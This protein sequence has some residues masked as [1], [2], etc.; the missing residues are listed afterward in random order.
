MALITG[1]SSG[2]GL[3][4]ALELA[5]AGFRVYATMRNLE[6]K[7]RLLAAAEKEKVSVEILELDV[8]NTASVRGTVE[9]VQK[10]EGQIDLLVNNA[11][12][13][14]GGFFETLKDEEIRAQL[15][16][17][18][19]GCINMI[20][21]VLPL[22]RTQRSGT[23]INVSSTSGLAGWPGLSAYVT[24]KFALEGFSESLWH[25][26]SPF[27]IN[28]VLIEPGLYPTEIVGENLRLGNE[29]KEERSG[30]YSELSK[31]LFDRF[32]Q[33]IE[34]L[35]TDPREVARLIGNVA[36]KKRPRLRYLAGREAKAYSL[37]S[38]LLP[39]RWLLRLVRK[40]ALGR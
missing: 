6:K 40:S 30:P 37:L 23:L 39:S 32:H 5:H 38:R 15:E 33:R 28:V 14:I 34:E 4:T 18:F 27:G 9:E 17:N 12:Y 29:M 35:K 7:D 10:R 20:R 1:S 11:G 31:N 36:K 2:F 3:L 21:E 19:Y 25:E 13:A 8:T 22:M 26:L 16:T 24:S